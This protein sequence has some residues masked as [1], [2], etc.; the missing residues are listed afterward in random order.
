MPRPGWAGR[1]A[2]RCEWGERDCAGLAALGGEKEECSPLVCGALLG[3]I[4]EGRF[5]SVGVFTEVFLSRSVWVC[6][7]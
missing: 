1:W 7:C 3:F 6:G 2:L 4:Y 5:F